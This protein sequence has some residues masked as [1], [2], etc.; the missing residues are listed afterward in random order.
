M[1]S[2]REIVAALLHHPVLDRQ[3]A[4]VTTAVTNLDVHDIARSAHTFGLSRF[5]VVHPVAAQRELVNRIR[6]HWVDGSGARR[7]PDRKPAME[8]VRIAS[9]FDDV[10]REVSAD[11]E[12]W[13]TS[14]ATGG[15]LALAAARER[16]AADGPP[17][18]IVFGTGWG[19]APEV[20][21]RAAGRLVG[22]RSPRS[23]GY[24]HLSVRAAAAIIFDRLFGSSAED[25]G[26]GL[27]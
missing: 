22:I 12:I 3:S 18:V 26:S 17:I 15:T 5:F 14:A 24:N 2:K 8:I 20:H 27:P 16:I 19:L 1:T 11:A 25:S 23:D 7:I 13:T 21:A 9:T 10:V 4:I 6:T